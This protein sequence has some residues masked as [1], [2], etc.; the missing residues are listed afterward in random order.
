MSG[1]ILIVFLLLSIPP[2]LL[3]PPGAFHPVDGKSGGG[4]PE[5]DLHRFS[6]KNKGWTGNGDEGPLPD[7]AFLKKPFRPE[8]LARKVREV[9]DG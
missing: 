7:A 9:L 1:L 4:Y 3:R 2:L 5:M 6:P 8:E